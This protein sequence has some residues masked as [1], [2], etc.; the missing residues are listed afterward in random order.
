MKRQV[1]LIGLT[2]TNGAGK[3]EAASFFV[4]NGYAYFS[5]S[6]LIREELRKMNLEITRN[7]LIRMGNTMRQKAG[8]DILARLTVKKIRGN[9]VID[10]IRNPR[11]V[12]F[13]K[14]LEHFT[15]LAIDAP[16]ETRFDRVKKRGRDESA[17]CL[18]E[19]LAKE[20]E[21]MGTEKSRQ[22]LHACM[23]MADHTIINDGTLEELQK[24]L[25]KFL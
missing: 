23:D 24:K 13:F 12:A 11:E 16:G 4:K 20:K 1:R 9:T 5:L 25:E 14:T 18:E 7:N 10:S 15:L 2:G 17:S 21:E 8:P 6:D 22:Q 3:G 19:F